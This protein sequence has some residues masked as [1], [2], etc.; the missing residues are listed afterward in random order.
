MPSI[1]EQDLNRLR[2]SVEELTA[3]NEIATA[4]NLS[5]SVETITRIILEN[6]LKRIPAAQGAVFLVADSTGDSPM[7]RTF[8]RETS[9]SSEALP[10]RLN[11][12]L[13]GWMTNN[14]RLL[15]MNNPVEDERF[16]GINFK[17]LGITSLLAAPLISRSGLIGALT[18][19]NKKTTEGFTGEDKRFLGIVGTQTAQVIEN[20]RL[21]ETEYALRAIEEEMKVA[22]SIQEG[23]LPHGNIVT[24]HF[25]ILGYNR[26]AKEV[27]GDYYDM[28]S[29]SEHEVVL[30]I[31]DVA[32]KGIPASLLAS[33]AQ[34]VIR[35]LLRH[36]PRPTLP[37]LVD[38]LNHLFVEM[39]RPE[40]YITAFIAI[41]DTRGRVL[42]YVNAGHCPPL[43]LSASGET[44]N[45]KEAG[46]IVGALEDA[47]YIMN[48]HQLHAGDTL[49]VCTDGIIENFGPGDEE[50]GEAR[51]QDFLMRHQGA[52]LAS[53]RDD[54]VAELTAFRQGI[55][56]SDDITFLTLRT[57]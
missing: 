13:L 44:E 11:W 26:P 42:R 57:K 55:P 47:G 19:F 24:D 3:L 18:L 41:Y 51:L 21:L 25:E 40:Q 43:V 39:T 29:V 31:G 27:G 5:I 34:A 33:E 49:F 16:P 37:D 53:T 9:E 10:L 52:A 8:I 6:C 20:T 2:A 4:I 12:S 46:L 54:L 45:L 1:S 38:S 30:S 14:K 22:K 28:F 48:E 36:S 7:F 17:D 56:Q 23:Y 15:A 50:Y 32:G 35:S